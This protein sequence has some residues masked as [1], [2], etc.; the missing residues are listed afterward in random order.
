VV[1][2]TLVNQRLDEVYK[3]RSEILPDLADSGPESLA[4][5]VA[6]LE[7]ISRPGG[8]GG[9][10]P[11]DPIAVRAYETEVSLILLELL[12][13]QEERISEL[14]ASLG[15]LQKGSKAKSGSTK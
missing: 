12:A 3:R 8:L 13:A 15:S 14:E 7:N 5:A 10:N 4:E 6:W 9:P 1:A 11:H 2:T